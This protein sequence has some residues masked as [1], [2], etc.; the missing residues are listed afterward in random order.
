MVIVPLERW[1]AVTK[2]ALTF[3]LSISPD[4]IGLH[5]ECEW[6]EQLKKEWQE[7]VEKPVQELG[8]A[9]P[10]LVVLAISLPLRQQSD[11]R[12]RAG[13]CRRRSRSVSSPC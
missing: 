4:V 13:S 12:L 7:F 2:K 10:R 5:V 11:C 6:T 3:A 1:S 9:A 8:L